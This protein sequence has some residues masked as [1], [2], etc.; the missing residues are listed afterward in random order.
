MAT[1]VFSNRSIQIL[2]YKLAG[3][4]PA[5]QYKKLVSRLNHVNDQ[6]LDAMWEAVFLGCLAHE[7]FFLHE[8]VVGERS[9]PDFQYAIPTPDGNLSIVGDV[10]AVSD[11]GLDDLNP[12]E[13]IREQIFDMAE[14]A[15]LDP[16]CFNTHVSGGVKGEWP[17]IKTGLDLGKKKLLN[18]MLQDEVRPFIKALSRSEDAPREFRPSNIEIGLTV[19]YVPNQWASSGGHVSYDV[20]HSP[21]KNH[22]Y[23][24]LRSKSDQLRGAADDAVRLIVLCDNDCAAMHSSMSGVRASEIAQE[25]LNKTKTVD[26]VLLI[27]VK[28][29]RSSPQSY[30]DVELDFQFV[31][32]AK[33]NRLS[34][35]DKKALLAF[36]ERVIAHFPDPIQD[37]C[38]ARIRALS[39]QFDSFDGT[40]MTSERMITLSVRAIQ[41]LLA[42]KHTHEEFNK[43]FRWHDGDRPIEGADELTIYPNPFVQHLK[44]GRLITSA[45]VIDGG[46]S[47]DHMIEVRFGPPDAG[48][49]K[50]R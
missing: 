36:L 46:D 27:A 15:G 49:S 29:K 50:F 16:N 8:E 33:S 47:D 17:K 37:P 42:G 30:R 39:G 20:I 35:S 23:E 25:F 1:F 24:A 13:W 2:L 48:A 5:E 28:K 31:R 10:T 19:K 4:L 38:N 44:E 32:S 12:I 21:T 7:T 26:G 9:R 43:L 34:D 40:L 22:V 14:R 3:V 18:E 11:K 41:E 6:R 45:K